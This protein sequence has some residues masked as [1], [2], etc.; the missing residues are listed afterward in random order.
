[1][2]TRCNLC[3]LQPSFG[4]N[5]KCCSDIDIRKFS[6]ILRLNE[7]Y[8]RILHIAN[9]STRAALVDYTSGPVVVPHKWK[10]E[11]GF[12][13]THPTDKNVDYN[14]DINYISGP[15]VDPHKWKTEKGF[16][17]T[18]PTDKNVDYNGNIVVGSNQLDP[19]YRTTDKGFPLTHPTDESHPPY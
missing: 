11:K 7:R 18:H 13:V 12:P 2:G 8:R 1:M 14:G 19:P 4:T 17:V 6:S 3:G 15:V 9:P 10:T 5:L 16:P